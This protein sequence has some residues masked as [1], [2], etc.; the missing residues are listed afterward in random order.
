MRIG[1]EN[2]E[3]E[4]ELIFSILNKKIGEERY[5]DEILI[6]MIKKNVSTSDLLFL[7]FKE[8][9]QRNL[10]E[11]SG[12]ISKILEK[13]NEEIKNEI[14][15]KI[16]ERLEKNRK[17]F[18]TPLDV[19]KYF[20]CPR[21]LWLEKIVLAKQYKEKV[22]KVWDGELVHYATH[23]F[24]VN[25]GKDE[26]SKIIENAVEQA[27]EKYK[28]KITLEKERV[29]D[30]LWSIDNFLKEE[31]FEIIFSEKQLESIKI[32]LVGKPDIIGIKKDGN[33]VAMDVKFGE[34]GKKGI[35]K[36]H[37]IQNIGESLLVE[38][39]FRKEV[40]ECF[41]IYFSSNATAS[42]QINEKDKKEFLKLKRSIEKLVKT[43]KIPPK[44]KLPN[45]RK[46]VC[47]GCHVRKSCE[48]IENYRR[49][50]F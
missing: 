41:L 21:R 13:I 22:G 3:K 19:T 34:I 26:I 38:N 12:R 37:L 40:N 14:K 50:R 4:I 27:F 17:L 36:E 43:N 39:F 35:K 11:G 1:V 8:L 20:Q 48:N 33:V 18:V 46:R 15:K 2:K 28:N 44:S 6:E 10:M 45:Y 47:Q 29:I 42:I 31:N 23:L 30:F 24:I 49:I 5:L 7:I 32:G 9:K 16:L 25:R